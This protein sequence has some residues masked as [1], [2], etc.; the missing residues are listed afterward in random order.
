MLVLRS[1]IY[2]PM[3]P[4]NIHAQCLRQRAHQH[5]V[6][7]GERHGHTGPTELL[8][9]TRQHV[10]VFVVYF[11]VKH[12]NGGKIRLRGH[13]VL[14]LIAAI[15]HVVNRIRQQLSHFP[16]DGAVGRTNPLPR[17]RIGTID[18]VPHLNRLAVL[19]RPWSTGRRTSL[20][21]RLAKHGQRGPL[22]NGIRGVG[23][24][25]IGVVNRSGIGLKVACLQLEIDGQGKVL[26]R[27]ACFTCEFNGGP[28]AITIEKQIPHPVQTP[29]KH[30]G[31]DQKE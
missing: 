13:Y 11:N 25:G 26:L 15:E 29:E 3:V 12:G 7:R 17:K 10:V 22:S 1:Y 20:P 23:G 28:Y 18:G 6:V 24:R 21:L 2:I 8:F 30:R 9:G 5:T 4:P 14:Q 16:N 31:R 27:T 19:V